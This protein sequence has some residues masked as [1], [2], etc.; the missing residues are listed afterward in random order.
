MALGKLTNGAEHNIVVY[1][2]AECALRRVGRSDGS[3]TS[4]VPHSYR[5][6][7]S[8]KEWINCQNI[9][10]AHDRSLDSGDRT[11]ERPIERSKICVLCCIVL[12]MEC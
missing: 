4:G 12:L 1:Q 7:R 3:A 8:S 6:S 2:P 10:Y 11:E 9:N 5:E